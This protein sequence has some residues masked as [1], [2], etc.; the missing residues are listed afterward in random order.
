MVFMKIVPVDGA[1]PLTES[2]AANDESV[3]N[4]AHG[5]FDIGCRS[6]FDYI[7]Y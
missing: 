5:A 3:T 2:T 6:K 1:V 7:L 4:N